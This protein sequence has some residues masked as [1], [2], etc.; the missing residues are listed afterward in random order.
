MWTH[1]SV[2]FLSRLPVLPASGCRG[3]LA[4]SPPA[5][6]VREDASQGEIVPS[7]TG[8]N[9]ELPPRAPVRGPGRDQRAAALLSFR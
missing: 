7:R 1:V 8:R 4:R 6:L 3:R 9:T 5:R 2:I